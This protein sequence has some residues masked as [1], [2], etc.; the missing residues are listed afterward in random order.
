MLTGKLQYR[1][2]WNGKLILQVQY[3]S[4]RY[5]S[6][7]PWGFEDYKAWRDATFEDLYN[8]ERGLIKGEGDGI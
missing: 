4:Q 7:T 5:S 3:A 2:S 8:L 6:L 1:K